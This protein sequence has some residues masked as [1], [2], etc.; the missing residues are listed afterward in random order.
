[1]AFSDTKHHL[2]YFYSSHREVINRLL[3]SN[4]LFKKHLEDYGTPTV[5]S[6]KPT[7]TPTHCECLKET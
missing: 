1:M 6:F 3:L 2:F 4:I 5:P 7:G